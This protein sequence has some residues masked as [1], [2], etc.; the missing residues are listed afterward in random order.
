MSNELQHKTVPDFSQRLQGWYHQHHRELPWRGTRD[1][2]RIW[3][4]EIILQQTRVAQGLPYYEAFLNAFPTVEHFA[5]ASEEEVLRLWQGLGYYSRARNMHTTARRV[6]EEYG[7]T[8]PSTYTELR[9]LKGVGPYTAA[10]IASF[11]FQ[12]PVAV[13]DGN[14]F[15]VLARIFGIETDIK[16][17]AAKKEFG[18]LARQLLDPEHPDIHN[19]A[20]MEFGA[21]HCT[22]KSPACASCPF[23][24]ECVAFREEK[25]AILPVK[26]KKTKVRERYFHY[27]VF[28]HDNQTLVRRRPAGDIWQGLYDFF[29]L[30][31]KE[32]LSENRL[33]EVHP[34]GVLGE[35][36]PIYKHQ[37]SHQRLWVRFWRV[38]V[39]NPE[40]WERLQQAH[41][42]QAAT[43]AEMEQ[44]PKPVLIKKYLDN[45]KV[46]LF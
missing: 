22:P 4:S 5:A 40:A 14:V 36:S 23:R 2:Y 19:Q 6:V 16:S 3:L 18:T 34:P 33:Q 43:T 15:R 9:K 13:V 24:A 28:Q 44:L 42:L 38:V 37:L 41:G 30:E 8:F 11:A 7:R 26:S 46:S 39:E 21:T 12:E 32:W 27:L 20:V 1:P 25:Q 29:L 31:A 17:A 10:A 45:L 35:P